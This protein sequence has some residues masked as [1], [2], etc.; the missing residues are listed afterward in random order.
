MLFFLYFFSGG[1]FQLE[2]CMFSLIYAIISS[3]LVMALLKRNT[4]KKI[5]CELKIVVLWAILLSSILVHTVINRNGLPVVNFVFLALVC[6]WAGIIIVD[7]ELVV[8]KC[9]MSFGLCILIMFLEL[10]LPAFL[11]VLSHPELGEIVYYEA[12][13]MIFIAIFPFPLLLGMISSLF[14]AY[15]GEKIFTNV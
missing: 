4:V 3:L 1:K 5:F 14:G 11:R 12:I 7:I 9:L 8:V 10:S 15:I 6:C 13:K 2:T